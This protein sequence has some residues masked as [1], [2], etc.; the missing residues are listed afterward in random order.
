MGHT[1]QLLRPT[2]LSELRGSSH[3]FLGPE[4][5]SCHLLNKAEEELRTVSPAAARGGVVLRL[6]HHESEGIIGAARADRSDL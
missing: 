2:D 3:D 6:C 5:K 1:N 4:S